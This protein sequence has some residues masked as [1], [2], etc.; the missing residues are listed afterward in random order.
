MRHRQVLVDT[1]AEVS[2]FEMV[3]NLARSAVVIFDAD[4]RVTY[5]NAAASGVLGLAPDD[6]IGRSLAWFRGRF[7]DA[8]PVG[9]MQ[10]A[11]SD[12]QSWRDVVL[13]HRGDGVTVRAEMSVNPVIDHDGS[14]LYVVAIMTTRHD[15]GAAS[16]SEPT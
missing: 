15:E 14:L 4:G 8:A 5:V 2:A 13:F 16:P 10:R 7:V 11:I 12:H 3:T 9:A 6:V 1:R